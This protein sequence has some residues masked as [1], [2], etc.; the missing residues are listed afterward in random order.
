MRRKR[1]RP[2]SHAHTTRWLGGSY[3]RVVRGIVTGINPGR[4]IEIRGNTGSTAVIRR[5][6]ARDAAAAP[7]PGRQPTEIASEGGRVLEFAKS[8]R[9]SRS[10]NSKERDTAKSRSA[11]RIHTHT[12]MLLH[13]RILISSNSLSELRCLLGYRNLGIFPGYSSLCK[14]RSENLLQR[15]IN[16]AV[17]I[18]SLRVI[19]SS[20]VSIY[21][22]ALCVS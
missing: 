14:R 16:S 11:G 10:S 5:K 8:A 6:I 17:F 13:A 22:I 9:S 7:K 18:G 19:F 3:T 1:S 15:P 21:I 4:E 2:R 12:L 20:A